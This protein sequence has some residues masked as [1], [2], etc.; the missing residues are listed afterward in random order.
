MVKV[1][2]ST[3][4]STTFTSVLLVAA[5]SEAEAE[6]VEEM[7]MVKHPNRHGRPVLLYLVGLQLQDPAPTR[8]L[9]IICPSSSRKGILIQDS[10]RDK[11]NNDKER[12]RDNLVQ[13]IHLSRVW[14][15]N[16]HGGHLHGLLHLCLHHHHCQLYR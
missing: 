12:R 10:E 4:F 15:I 2:A 11:N 1:G 8:S 3:L 5:P 7:P 16:R 13:V 9:L 6:E 14:S